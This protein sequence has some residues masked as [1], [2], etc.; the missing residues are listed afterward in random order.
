MQRSGTSE[1]PNNEYAKDEMITD[2]GLQGPTL[3]MSSVMHHDNNISKFSFKVSSQDA[4]RCHQSAPNRYSKQRSFK[5][6]SNPK[7]NQEMHNVFN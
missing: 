7:P 3:T 1:T 2:G 6:T 5:S 4:P